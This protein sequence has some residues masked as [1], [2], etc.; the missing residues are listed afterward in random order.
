MTGIRVSPGSVLN[1]SVEL[2][3]WEVGSHLNEDRAER[4]MQ[5][6]NTYSCQ[7]LVSRTRKISYTAQ[8]KLVSPSTRLNL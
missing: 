2:Q 6:I 4:H 7:R 1:E 5:R 3:N 8:V